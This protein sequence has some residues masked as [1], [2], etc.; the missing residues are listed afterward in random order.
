MGVMETGEYQ[1][2]IKRADSGDDVARERLKEFRGERK[3]K[4][5][6]RIVPNPAPILSLWER[7]KRLEERSSIA[8]DLA[9]SVRPRTAV[10]IINSGGGGK[11]A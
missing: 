9:D 4:P 11:A 2:L 1:N 3:E 5:A 6:L 8:D 10:D 7:V